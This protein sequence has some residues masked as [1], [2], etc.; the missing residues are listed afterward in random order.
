MAK[1]FDFGKMGKGSPTITND[2]LGIFVSDRYE[3]EDVVLRASEKTTITETGEP[4]G[5]LVAHDTVDGIEVCT[6]GIQYLWSRSQGLYWEMDFVLQ[7]NYLSFT[8][9][10]VD[11]VFG[12]V[13]HIPYLST[14]SDQGAGIDDG[15]SYGPAVYYLLGQLH[16]S[17]F[18]DASEAGNDSRVLEFGR[19]ES[20]LRYTGW[21]HNTMKLSEADMA[22]YNFDIAKP[23][24]IYGMT[25]SGKHL[26]NVGSTTPLNADGT[27]GLWKVSY[28]GWHVRP[29]FTKTKVIL[30]VHG[31]LASQHSLLKPMLDAA[32]T[33]R[34][35]LMVHPNEVGGAGYMSE[36]DIKLWADAG[37]LIGNAGYDASPSAEVSTI[38]LTDAEVTS[39]YNNAK[40]WLEAR[41]YYSNYYSYIQ[42]GQDFE[43]SEFGGTVPINST[44]TRDL[45]VAEGMRSSRIGFPSF[46]TPSKITFDSTNSS[47]FNTSLTSLYNLLS[48]STHAYNADADDVDLLG[49]LDYYVS[50]NCMIIINVGDIAASSPTSYQS[51]E[52]RT[53]D[54]IDGLEARVA[55]GE[56]EVV[57]YNTYYYQVTPMANSPSKD[58]TNSA[59]R[60]TAGF[61]NPAIR[62]DVIDP[63]SGD[64]TDLLGTRI[65][66]GEVNDTTPSADSIKPAED[67]HPLVGDGPCSE[68]F[69]DPSGELARIDSASEAVFITHIDISEATTNRPPLTGMF[70]TSNWGGGAVI[71]ISTGRMSATTWAESYGFSSLLATQQQSTAGVLVGS[72]TS[73]VIGVRI[74]YSG[75]TL[76]VEVYSPDFG[77]LAVISATDT[78]FNGTTDI[79]AGLMAGNKWRPCV[80]AGGAK[81]NLLYSDIGAHLTRAHWKTLVEEFSA[82]MAVNNRCLVA[83]TAR[84]GSGY[85]TDIVTAGGFGVLQSPLSSP[86]ST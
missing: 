67:P 43:G 42:D 68:L 25:H 69:A 34:A 15:A 64:V 41:G 8:L 37:H 65:N 74:S 27:R 1:V 11:D 83:A 2:S 19:H 58:F 12:P 79:G 52:A 81:T 6:F 16:P 30:N 47:V 4:V 45:M 44:R 32:P 17:E 61:F 82:S 56:L 78:T 60:K 26:L 66:L 50:A 54:L 3:Y 57:N 10:S 63:V 75:I 51:L 35:N 36:A 53:Q 85:R 20:G 86:L 70:D 73:G 71:D 24:Y 46:S 31:A 13:I 72:V 77:Q 84:Q 49:D 14:Y 18:A 23:F 48:V 39:N 55:A 62:G 80:P 40:A 33:V 76:T 5:T 21:Q 38:L 59:A 9:N 29:S 22:L 7:G 28:E